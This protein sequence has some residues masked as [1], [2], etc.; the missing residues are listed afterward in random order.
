[1][2]A[3]ADQSLTTR[4]NSLWG[5]PAEQ[6][7]EA[8]A[9]SLGWTFEHIGANK[10]PLDGG[11]TRRPFK[12]QKTPDYE[13]RKGDSP[14][15]LVEVKGCNLKRKADYKH[16]ED[17]KVKVK[18]L[19][20]LKMWSEDADIYLFFYDSGNKAITFTSLNIVIEAC[21]TAEIKVFKDG[22]EY[23]SLSPHTFVWG[24]IGD[25]HATT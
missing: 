7:F 2:G 8:W 11:F 25:Y 5:G 3:Y 12:T 19:E 16:Y 17:V 4:F 14:P 20:G 21:Q 6:Q 24:P 22:N 10:E 1:M 15:F 9:S 23:Y 18:D 13:C